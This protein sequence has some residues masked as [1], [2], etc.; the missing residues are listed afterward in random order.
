MWETLGVHI[1]LLTLTYLT[2]VSRAEF[3]A[4][5]SRAVPL[6]I[7]IGAF[8]L[9]ITVA[10]ALTSALFE[11]RGCLDKFGVFST[12]LIYSA[13]AICMFGISLVSVLVLFDYSS[14]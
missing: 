5:M 6:S 14:T 7:A 10:E 9:V 8:S 4:F 1:S 3:D 11:V 12:T 13:A 2:V